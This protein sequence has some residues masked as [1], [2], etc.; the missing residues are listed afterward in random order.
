MAGGKESAWFSLARLTPSPGSL[1]GK[2]AFW[3][4]VNWGNMTWSQGGIVDL[5]QGAD[6][7]FFLTDWLL[8]F[9]EHLNN[10]LDRIFVSVGRLIWC[11]TQ[12]STPT[13]L[14]YVLWLLYTNGLDS[15]SLEMG[16]PP[17]LLCYHTLYLWPL[18]EGLARW[19]CNKCLLKG[20]LYLYGDGNC[21]YLPC[22]PG[23]GAG[24]G[25]QIGLNFHLE[26]H[27]LDLSVLILLMGI[28]P[29]P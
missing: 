7:F 4:E 6:F 3:L 23:K 17:H 13:I 16:N 8:A 24:C 12:N 21:F 25:S 9:E 27:W 14:F 18:T 1:G 19:A 15:W 20:V 26:C 5:S 28:R 11:V 29:S 2:C 22:G 10:S